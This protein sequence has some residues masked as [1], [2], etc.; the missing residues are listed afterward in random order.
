MKYKEHNLNTD[1]YQEFLKGELKFDDSAAKGEEKFTRLQEVV[2]A[3]LVSS[4]FKLALIYFVFS[5][6][7]YILNLSLCAQGPVGRPER[8][9]QR[10]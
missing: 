2:S 9:R 4:K 7:G 3:D 5:S 10:R 1:D 8:P 6:I